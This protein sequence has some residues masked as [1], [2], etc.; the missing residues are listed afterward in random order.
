M[1]AADAHFI[2]VGVFVSRTVQQRFANRRA[3][4]FGIAAVLAAPG[5]ELRCQKI[6]IAIVHECSRCA[7]L[8]FHE[9]RIVSRDRSSTE[10]L[11]HGS[12]NTAYHA[13]TQ[14]P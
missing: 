1:A 12:S 3:L 4:G 10:P 13:A 14:Q 9:R 2:L 8:E 11:S 7:V 6:A 5:D